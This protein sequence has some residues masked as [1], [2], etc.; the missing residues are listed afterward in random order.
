[1]LSKSVFLALKFCS[2]AVITRHKNLDNTGH[3][4]EAYFCPML[5]YGS[6]TLGYKNATKIDSVQN[7]GMRVF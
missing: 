3:T 4:Y 1:M 7:K 6:E 5:D 2:R